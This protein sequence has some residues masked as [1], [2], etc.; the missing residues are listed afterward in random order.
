MAHAEDGELL[1][2]KQMGIGNSVSVPSG[3]SMSVATATLED[4]KMFPRSGRG[5]L[6]GRP[7]IGHPNAVCSQ[8]RAAGFYTNMPRRYLA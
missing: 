4:E 6:A 8:C 1:G 2:S 3:L 7:Y 5:D